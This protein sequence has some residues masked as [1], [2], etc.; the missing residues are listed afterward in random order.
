MTSHALPR[1]CAPCLLALAIVAAALAASAS[2]QCEVEVAEF[3]PADGHVGDGF[4]Y[5]VE[6]IPWEGTDAPPP[7]L[8]ANLDFGPSPVDSTPK[9]P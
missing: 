9:D 2:A 3:E 8:V 5:R 4:G 6:T 1:R 7:D